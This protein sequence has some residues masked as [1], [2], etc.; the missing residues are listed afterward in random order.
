MFKNICILLVGLILC[1]G[2]NQDTSEEVSVYIEFE[3]TEHKYMMDFYDDGNLYNRSFDYVDN[4][5]NDDNVFYH[6]R[7]ISS[8][9]AEVETV[10]VSSDGLTLNMTNPTYEALTNFQSE[11]IPDSPLVVRNEPYQGEIGNVLSIMK[12]NIAGGGPRTRYSL[13]TYY[14]DLESGNEYSLEMLIK[15]KLRE[16]FYLSV[17]DMVPPYLAKRMPKSDKYSHDLY[18][19]VIFHVTDQGLIFPAIIIPGE[20]KTY[21][22]EWEQINDYL[23]KN[24]DFYKAVFMD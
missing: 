8:S 6:A 2:C 16:E 21:F 22:L 12:M 18:K 19:E 20:I 3:I 14:F 15:P 23:D 9:K 11:E 24:S 13:A 7:N 10:F 4:Y 5:V 17:I 1:V